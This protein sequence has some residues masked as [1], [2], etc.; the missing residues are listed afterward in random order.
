MAAR[1]DKKTKRQEILDRLNSQ[2]T[3]PHY[4]EGQNKERS[5]NDAEREK[6]LSKGRRGLGWVVGGTG[7]M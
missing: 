6:A 1:K 5:K 2:D 7:G 3:G 4:G